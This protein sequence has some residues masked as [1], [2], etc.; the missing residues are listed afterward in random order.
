MLA[1]GGVDGL[2]AG[3]I[4]T[5]AHT[6]R[7]ALM[8]IKTKPDIP[9]VSSIFFMC[10]PKQVLVYGD[11]AVNQNPTSAELADIAI[12]CADSAEQ[13]G[14]PPRVAMISYST[15]ASGTGC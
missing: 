15:G 7:P 13:F 8:L 11:C 6:I 3:T 2:V 4:H 14:I 9:R 10:L 12:Q 5:T 1:K